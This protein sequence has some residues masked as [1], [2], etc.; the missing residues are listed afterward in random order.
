MGKTFAISSSRHW[1]VNRERTPMGSSAL[2]ELIIQ[3]RD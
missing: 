1:Y 3:F 2:D